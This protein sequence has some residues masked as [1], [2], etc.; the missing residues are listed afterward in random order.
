MNLACDKK[1]RD[2]WFCGIGLRRLSDQI[3]L[4]HGMS[5]IKPYE[6]RGKKPKYEKTYRDEIREENGLVH[7]FWFIEGAYPQCMIF[8]TNYLMME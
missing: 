6:K 4:E 2:S 8:Q 5:V 3:C 7:H 1:F